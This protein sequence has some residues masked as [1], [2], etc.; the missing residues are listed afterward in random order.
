MFPRTKE[1][2]FGVKGLF[3]NGGQNGEYKRESTKDVKR[4]QHL[5]FAAPDKNIFGRRNIT[6]ILIL[7]RHSF[8]SSFSCLSFS[9]IAFIIMCRIGFVIEYLILAFFMDL[10]TMGFGM[11]GKKRT[12]MVRY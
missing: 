2:R 12:C 4:E 3:F 11:Y 6:V 10:V 8:S 9:L 5:S 7:L 1:G